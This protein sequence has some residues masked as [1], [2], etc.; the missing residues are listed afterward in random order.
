MRRALADIAVNGPLAQEFAHLEQVL[1]QTISLL[2]ECDAPFW[3]P[4][5]D[6][7]L[8]QIANHHLAGATYILGCFGGQDTFSD[9][10]IATQWQSSDP[11]R[12]NNANARLNHLRNELFTAADAIAS[13]RHW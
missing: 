11:L 8:A 5:L 9:L 13:R 6:R 7:G 10:V 3:V 1:R 2:R 4:V 12:F